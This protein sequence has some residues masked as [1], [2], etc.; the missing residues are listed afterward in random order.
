M[1]RH[2]PNTGG[3]QSMS[4]IVEK[5]IAMNHVQLIQALKNSDVYRQPA[6]HEKTIAK[7]LSGF[8]TGGRQDF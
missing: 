7:F 8:I 4:F 6:F 5:Q 2:M 1:V 3:D